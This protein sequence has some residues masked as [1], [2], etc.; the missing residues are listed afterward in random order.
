MTVQR[1]TFCPQVAAFV[2]AVAVT[3]DKGAQPVKVFRVN[4]AVGSGFTQM[5]RVM[6]SIPQRLV[7]VMIRMV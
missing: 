3:F 7:P 1:N 5:V 4:E 6:V 2:V